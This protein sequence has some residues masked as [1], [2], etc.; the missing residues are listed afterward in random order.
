MIVFL[1]KKFKEDRWAEFIMKY[2]EKISE[3]MY[4]VFVGE[5]LVEI[6]VFVFEVFGFDIGLSILSLWIWWFE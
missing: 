3:D 1:I 5:E 2:L 4:C 6:W